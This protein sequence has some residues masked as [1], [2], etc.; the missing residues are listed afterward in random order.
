[1]EPGALKSYV[2]D[3][4]STEA[5]MRPHLDKVGEA[6]NAL[7]ERAR[8]GVFLARD[9]RMGKKI[10]EQDLVVVRPRT[11]LSPNDLKLVVGRTARR[12]LKKYE[13]VSFDQV[14]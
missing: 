7:A 10:T 6:E 11:Q 12:D 3:I 8:R 1:M 4:R 5:A 14:D 13:P 2:A 9:V